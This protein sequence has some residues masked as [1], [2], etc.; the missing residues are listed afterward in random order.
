MLRHGLRQVS[1]SRLIGLSALCARV[2]FLVL[3]CWRGGRVVQGSKFTNSF[4]SAR[5]WV[6]AAPFRALPHLQ[7]FVV[8]CR[9]HPWASR[10][11]DAPVGFN[12]ASI[13]VKDGKVSLNGFQ[14]LLDDSLC[15]AG[16]HMRSNIQEIVRC[17]GFS[18]SDFFVT[19]NNFSVQAH[20][21]LTSRIFEQVSR[22]RIQAKWVDEQLRCDAVPFGGSFHR[23]WGGDQPSAEIRGSRGELYTPPSKARSPR[24]AAVSA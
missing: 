13:D 12:P 19:L 7:D 23:A 1:A 14:K 17:D 24:S 5:R 11:N 9:V 10:V 8:E 3:F 16:R 6:P 20:R 21:P 18:F 4:L 2:S 15:P 22:V